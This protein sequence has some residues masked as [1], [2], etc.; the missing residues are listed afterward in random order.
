MLSGKYL[1]NLDSEDEGQIFIGCAGG[2]DTVATLN[3]RQEEPVK[4][5]EFFRI[6]VSGLLGGHSGDDIEKGRANSNKVLNRF[7]WR[8][9]ASDIDLRLAYF[10]GGNLR[11][12]IPREAFAVFGV[13]SREVK[14]VRRFFEE[15]RDDLKREY[16]TIETGMDLALTDMPAPDTVMDVEAQRSLLDA[17][18]GV[19]NGVLA[20]SP[21]M[22]GMVET[23]TNLAS[24]KF[25]GELLVEI[26]TSQRSAIQSARG[27]RVG[28]GRIGAAA[29]RRR[30]KSFGRLS[31]LESRSG[32][33]AAGG[34]PQ[35]L[36]QAVRR[37]TAGAVDPCRIGVRSVLAKISRS[38]DDI[39][40]S[41]PSRRTF[42]GREAGDRFRRTV[43]AVS[44]R[45]TRRVEKRRR[46]VTAGVFRRFSD[47]RV[48]GS[49]C[50]PDILLALRAGIRRRPA[51]LRV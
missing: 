18:C 39:H 47:N 23:S 5:Y 6:D 32:F 38:G 46:S 48:S 43:L 44:D 20:M 2:I 37:A 4:N 22:P 1:I 27:C 19:P 30:R 12:A 24:V 15:F 16:G 10:D 29:G 51:G 36:R 40:R 26:T 28:I 41:D 7:L 31:G 21:V 8:I 50:G 25:V 35:C 33:Q 9:D 34:G 3:Y 49:F 42:A 13:P 11:N 45:N 17:V 14:R